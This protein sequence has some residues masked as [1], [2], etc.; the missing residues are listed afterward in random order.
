MNKSVLLS[1]ILLATCTDEDTSTTTFSTLVTTFSS[2]SSPST[3]ATAFDTWSPT[4]EHLTS[5][6]SEDTFGASETSAAVGSTSE[7][8]DSTS[9]GTSESSGDSTGTEESTGDDPMTHPPKG[10]AWLIEVL[11]RTTVDLRYVVVDMSRCERSKLATLTFQ[12]ATPSP[13]SWQALLTRRECGVFGGLH[14][15]AAMPGFGEDG[16]T[17]DIEG[18]EGG[19]NI[20]VRLEVDGEVSDEMILPNVLKGQSWQGEPDAPVVPVRRRE[21]H[22]WVPIEEHVPGCELVTVF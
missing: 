10:C 21:D 5:E 15:P 19:T 8:D 14:S 3:N 20:L 7:G 4:D 17:M 18:T 2:M 12:A 6:G 16:F 9:S 11:G 1:A 13:S 22:S